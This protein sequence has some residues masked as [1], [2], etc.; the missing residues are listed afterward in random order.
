MRDEYDDEEETADG[1]VKLSV[2]G[3]MN[4]LEDAYVIEFKSLEKTEEVVGNGKASE[5]RTGER[6]K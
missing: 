4:A 6:R 3:R 2:V 1:D 5:T